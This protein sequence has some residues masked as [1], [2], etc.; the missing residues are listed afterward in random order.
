MMYRTT[1]EWQH[2]ENENIL[3]ELVKST[4]SEVEAILRSK[5]SIK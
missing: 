1:E 3:I 2:I 5:K 4:D